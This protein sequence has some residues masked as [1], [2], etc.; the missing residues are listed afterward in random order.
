[1]VGAETSITTLNM[2]TKDIASSVSNAL[3]LYGERAL[4]PEGQEVQEAPGGL[5]EPII[6]KPKG[7]HQK[8]FDRLVR[9]EREQVMP[10]LWRWLKRWECLSGWAGCNTVMGPSD[11]LKHTMAY[12]LAGRANCSDMYNSPQRIKNHIL[13]FFRQ[14]FGSVSDECCC[15]SYF[16][17]HSN[18]I[19]PSK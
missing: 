10:P 13:M 9:K 12:E 8:T 19:A 1:M 3:G 11:R 5:T 15:E 6:W 16:F 2:T 18:R 17:I 7:M 14:Y 4:K